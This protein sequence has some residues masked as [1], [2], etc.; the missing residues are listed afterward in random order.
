MI[1]KC[2]LEKCRYCPR[3]SQQGLNFANLPLLGGCTLIALKHLDA[4]VKYVDHRAACCESCTVGSPMTV[5]F[6]G[7]KPYGHGIF[8]HR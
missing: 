1:K 8:F 5:I 7:Q 4:R 2:S 3:P 6:Y